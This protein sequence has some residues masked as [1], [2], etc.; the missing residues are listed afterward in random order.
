MINL[1]LFSSNNE[2]VSAC[3]KTFTRMGVRCEWADNIDDMNQQLVRTPF[4]GVVLDVQTTARISPKDRIF[5]Q[6]VSEYYPSLLMRWNKAAQKIGGLVF[7]E[8]L[9]KQNPLEDFVTRFCRAERALIYRENKRYDIHFNVLLSLDKDFSGETVEKTVTL[10]LSR[11]GC[12]IISSRNWNNIDYAWIRL[13]E[14]ADPSPIRV[15]LCRYLP[16]GEQARIPGI[17]I[18]FIDLQ[19]GQRQEID[20]HCDDSPP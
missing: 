1:L 16:W 19:P 6:E 2:A 8:I 3:Q 15:K 5:L 10:D 14:L 13:L 17:G 20:Q 7:G 18:R 9:D 11:G 12:F 4:N